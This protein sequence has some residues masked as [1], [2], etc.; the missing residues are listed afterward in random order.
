MKESINE[1]D[2][3]PKLTLHNS[4][5]FFLHVIGNP[6]MFFSQYINESCYPWPRQI[7]NV[8]N[9]TKI[10]DDLIYTYIYLY[11]G[12]KVYKFWDEIFYI[13]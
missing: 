9:V 7:A 6:K 11:R 10:L 8:L 2:I 1:E 3:D 13:C 4:F 5:R 12:K